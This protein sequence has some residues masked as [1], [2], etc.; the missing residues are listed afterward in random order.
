MMDTLAQ[1]LAQQ[2]QL[3]RAL[4]VQRKAVEIAPDAHDLRL[5]L[6]QLLVQQGDTE[7]AR[8]QL[9]ALSRLGD[10]Y[11]RQSDVRA[12]LTSLPGGSS[13]KFTGS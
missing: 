10:A 3:P 1:V 6:A 5:R 13:K 4:Q 8:V 11:A 12:L 9:E 7:A 2:G